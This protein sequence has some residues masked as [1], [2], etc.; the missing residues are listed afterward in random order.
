MT[1]FKMLWFLI[2]LNIMTNIITKILVLITFNSIWINCFFLENDFDLSWYFEKTFEQVHSL[3]F[4]VTAFHLKKNCTLNSPNKQSTTNI[5]STANPPF[6]QIKQVGSQC[7]LHS[8]KYN[9]T[10]M[11]LDWLSI[12]T[13]MKHYLIWPLKK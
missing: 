11:I 6:W 7:Q 2:C 8:S 1:I 4:Q 10:K 5:G 3:Y 13:S 12:Y 9:Y